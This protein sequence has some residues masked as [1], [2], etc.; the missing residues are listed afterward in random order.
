MRRR[1]RLNQPSRISEKISLSDWLQVFSFV[2]K[3]PS[4]TQK[5][6]VTHFRTLATGALVFSQETLSR[7]LNPAK[8]QELEARV[9][10]NPTALSSKRERVVTRPD[11][12]RAMILWVQSMEDDKGETV[13][14]TC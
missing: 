9:G 1:H 7:K 11:V 14:G 13:T 5:E 6:V 3:H 2:D 4:M 8:R 12:E 10:S